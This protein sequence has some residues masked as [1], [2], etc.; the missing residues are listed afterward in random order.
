LDLIDDNFVL[1]RRS[2]AVLACL[3]GF[4]TFGEIVYA[5]SMEELHLLFE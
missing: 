4:I 1:K 2:F 3:Y 5:E